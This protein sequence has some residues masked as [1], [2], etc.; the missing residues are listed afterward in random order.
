MPNKKSK[1]S[2]TR[3]S[4]LPS[5]V[6]SQTLNLLRAAKGNHQGSSKLNALS[7][8]KNFSPTSRISAAPISFGKPS[9]SGSSRSPTSSSALTNL[10]SSSGSGSISKLVGSG[11]LSFGMS[12]LFSSISDLFGGSK[13]APPPLQKFSLPGSQHETLYST[14]DGASKTNFQN[15]SSSQGSSGIYTSSNDTAT[16]AA[17]VNAVKNALLTSSSLNDIIGEL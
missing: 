11:L 6:T 5:S 2:T 7:G 17:I 15:S 3:G 13:T 8:L 16:Q 4:K 12:S 14:S 10:L 1:T 9:K